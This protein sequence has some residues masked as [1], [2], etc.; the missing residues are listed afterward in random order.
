[1]NDAP[2]TRSRAASAPAEPRVPAWALAAITWINSLGSGLLWSGVPF[3]TEGRYG[4]TERQN[5]VLALVESV[6]YVG[7]ALGAGP[8]LRRLARRG[9][10]ARAWLAGVFVLQMAGSLLVLLGMWGVVAAACTLSAVGASAW[11]VLESYLSSGRHGHDM[12]RAI[13][14][15]NITWMSATGAALLL[16]GPILAAGHA[17]HTLLVLVPVSLASLVLLRWFPRQPA[18][19]STEEGARHVPPSYRGLRTAMRFILPVS[20]VFIAVIGPILPF[21]LSELELDMGA[22]T[23]LASLWMFARMATVVALAFLPFWHGR[24]SAIGMGVALLAG[25]FAAM[26][27]A[28]NAATMAAG[29]VAFGAGHGVLYYAGL[30]YAMAVGGAEV[31]AGG[32]F[33]ALIGVGY[34]IGPLAGLA[35]GGSAST[36][37]LAVWGIAATGMLPAAWAWRR[38]TRPPSAARG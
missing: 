29:L 7:V 24:W 25:G 38:S 20:Y 37:V 18:P 6:I 5:L 36:L 9:G 12:R 16:M 33:E 15:F 28:T 35:A 13:G 2:E 1:M 23:P 17:E 26:V 19:H 8:L 21:R 11:P 27:L 34:V 3:V 32:V 4:F 31:D 30:Y 10:S 14:W 22:R